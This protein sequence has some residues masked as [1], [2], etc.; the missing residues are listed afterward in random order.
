MY[1]GHD[2]PD[3]TTMDIKAY[4]LYEPGCEPRNMHIPCIRRGEDEGP[5]YTHEEEE[6]LINK[7]VEE[8]KGFDIDFKQF[9][10]VFNY[11]PLDF[12]DDEMAIEPETTRELMD[13]LSRESLEKYNEKEATHYEFVKVTKANYYNSAT[14]ATV[15][16]I[17]YQGKASSDDEPRDFRAK[18]VHNYHTPAKYISCEMKPYKNVHFIETAENEDA[19]RTKNSI[20]NETVQKLESD[21]RR[22]GDVIV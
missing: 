16:F 1:M 13:R 20:T 12:D 11:K 10:Y 9:R 19:K 4:L 2:L 21:G 6:R 8:S 7:Q 22:R 17:T 15:Y 14:A 18:V 3:W 5:Y